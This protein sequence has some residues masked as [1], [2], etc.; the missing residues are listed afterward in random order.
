MENLEIIKNENFEKK[1]KVGVN[2]D[3]IADD[4]AKKLRDSL[5][6]QKNA[7]T[8]NHF[9]NINPDELTNDDLIIFDKFQK[10]ILA[11]NEF[12]KYREKLDQYF[13]SQRQKKGKDFDFFKDSRSNFSAMILNQIINRQI[14]KKSSEESVGNNEKKANAA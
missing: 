12:K 13:T 14:Q 7:K 1:E 8:D 6:T 4:Y 9:E 2:L 3:K 5:R 10:N 11:D